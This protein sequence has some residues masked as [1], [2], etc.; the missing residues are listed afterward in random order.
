MR[1][2]AQPHVVKGRFSPESVA[3]RSGE[4][5]RLVFRLPP[6]RHPFTCQRGALYG[7]LVVR[8]GR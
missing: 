3:L 8:A 6:G 1:R 7:R 4:A 5:Q 2:D